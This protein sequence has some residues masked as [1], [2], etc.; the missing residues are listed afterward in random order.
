[1]QAVSRRKEKERKMKMPKRLYVQRIKPVNHC[2]YL[3]CSEELSKLTQDGPVAIYELREIGRV[4]TKSHYT[5]PKGAV[6]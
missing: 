4:D 2:P 1:M 5:S 6:S 3:E